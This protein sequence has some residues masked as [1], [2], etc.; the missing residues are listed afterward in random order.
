MISGSVTGVDV[1]IKGMASFDVV[2]KEGAFIGIEQALEAVV[3]PAAIKLISAQDH[4]LK[5]LADLGHPYAAAHPNPPHSD[6][7]VH[8]QTGEYLAGIRVELPKGSIDKVIEGRLINDDPKDRFI[9]DGTTTMIARPWMQHIIDEHGPEIAGVIE[10]VIKARWAM[11]DR[12][13]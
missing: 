5:E 12:S 8:V 3:K 2:T 1:V 9:Q 10:Q 6:P 7:I 4:S 11:E 13:A